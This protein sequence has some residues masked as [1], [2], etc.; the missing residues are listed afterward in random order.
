MPRKRRRRIKDEPIAVTAARMRRL[1]KDPARIA[2]NRADDC[3]N[4]A[5]GAHYERVMHY[6]LEQRYRAVDLGDV[7][8]PKLDEPDDDSTAEEFCSCG[9]PLTRNGRCPTCRTYEG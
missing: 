2:S 4:E 9:T 3:Q 1:Y 7:P 5:L 8:T 6:L